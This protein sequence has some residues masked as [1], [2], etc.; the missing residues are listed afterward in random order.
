M[1]RPISLPRLRATTVALYSP[2]WP[3]ANQCPRASSPWVKSWTGSGL[4]ASAPSWSSTVV[5]YSTPAIGDVLGVAGGG[6]EVELLADGDPPAIE[7][8]LDLV[9]ALV[10]LVGEP[11]DDLPPELA[12]REPALVGG[13][14]P[15][16]GLAAEGEDPA[17]AGLHADHDRHAAGR[18]RPGPIAAGLGSPNWFVPV[19]GRQRVPDPRGLCAVGADLEDVAVEPVGVGDELHPPC[20]L[21]LAVAG[22]DVDG[23]DAG[24][25][26]ARPAAGAEA[27]AA[28]EHDQPRPLLDGGGQEA[29]LDAGEVIGREVAEDVDVVAAGGELVVVD[30]GRL[31]GRAA[32]DLQLGLDVG[33]RRDRP[34]QVLVLPGGVGA[35]EIEDVQ[36]PRQHGDVRADLVV[37]PGA[38]PPPSA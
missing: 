2:G 22:V 21:D 23:E 29:L 3:V 31:A 15:D 16:P 8:D 26:G 13:A 4:A 37:R 33:G 30:L 6:G 24:Q 18:P 7:G 14:G 20:G 17:L 11:E 36:A 35:L 32:D 34:E 12:V 25:L 5:S 38:A 9:L 28:A 10:L 27:G 1:S 19:T